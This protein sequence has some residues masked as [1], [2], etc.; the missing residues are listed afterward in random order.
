MVRTH[1]K[2]PDL[3]EDVANL[4][5]KEL[6][7]GDD[8]P[9]I[10][11]SE[12]LKGDRLVSFELGKVYVLDFWATWCGPCKA[13]LPHFSDLQ[14][15]YP[16]AIFLGVAVMEPDLEKARSFIEEAG[17]QIRFRIVMEEP[18]L[19]CEDPLAGFARPGGW[20]A[21][22]WWY[23]SYQHGVPVT[24]IVTSSGE[25][26]WI[27]HPLEVEEPLSAVIK[28]SWD[29]SARAEAHREELAKTHVRVRFQLIQ[30]FDAAWKANDTEG[31]VRIVDEAFLSCP[32]LAQEWQFR[33]N[34]L[35]ALMKAPSYKTL[36]LEYASSLM[37]VEPADILVLM[38]VS[39]GLLTSEGVA[40]ATDID[41]AELA[42][43]TMQRIEPLLDDESLPG[44]PG[45]DDRM[46][47]EMYFVKALVTI[48]RTAEAMEH[49]ARA[50]QLCNDVAIHPKVRDGLLAEISSF[51]SPAAS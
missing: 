30:Q 10:M 28:G 33:S 11:F 27:G 32:E 5:I 45:V 42:V 7:V 1:Q 3:E 26:A 23:A 25:I 35:K 41:F 51:L 36:T 21:K 17:D 40:E 18:P 34:K 39:A 48:G 13:T 50:K 37:N 38:Q 16:Q 8:A 9:P 29:L 24:F 12:F 49:A 47:L 19:P 20:M 4:K 43:E 2:A 46:R 14:D 6:S 22:H 31:A 44:R 15:K